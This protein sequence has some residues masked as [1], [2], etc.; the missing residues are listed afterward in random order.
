[1]IMAKS[2]R[3]SRAKAL[4]RV[5]AGIVVLVSAI[6]CGS[7]KSTGLSDLSPVGDSL[8]P[9]ADSLQTPGIPAPPLSPPAD[10]TP[11]IVPTPPAVPDTLAPPSPPPPDPAPPPPAQSGIPFGAVDLWVDTTVLY[12]PEPFT[13]S[14]NSD[15]PET[16]VA[17]INAA[18]ALRHRLVLTM[19]GGMHSRYITN[20]K[21]DIAKWKTRQDLY[22]T[23]EIRAAVTAGLADGTVLMANIIDEPQHSSWGGVPNK[24]LMDEM[25]AH[26]K[27]IF[28]TLPVGVWAKPDWLP[29]E[30]YKVVDFLITQYVARYGSVT[31]WRDLVLAVAKEN[32]IA[33]LFAINPINGGM[34]VPSCP[35]GPTGGKGTYSNRC[36]MTPDQIRESGAV[37]GVAGCGLVVWR[38]E[39]KFMSRSENHQAFEDL[40]A[41]LS[42]KTAP[43]CRRP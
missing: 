23:P 9:P 25:A 27:R 24:E 28:P 20:D 11:P 39:Q 37:L 16:L 12:G 32:G 6:S 22:D 5:S 36:Q 7:D 1:M 31:A 15:R 40:A 3:R 35:V 42:S 13:M 2:L 8:V 41:K 38:Y 10:S 17:R 43:P 18:R 30:R 34:P 26:V 4:L 29:A 14:I 21:F 33:V 19:T